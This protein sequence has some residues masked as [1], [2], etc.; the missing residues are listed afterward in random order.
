[1]LYSL[2]TRVSHRASSRQVSV[3]TPKRSCQNA[4]K[5]RSLKR[6]FLIQHRST[7]HQFP[8]I[9]LLPNPHHTTTKSHT[10]TLLQHPSHHHSHSFLRVDGFTALML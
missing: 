2:F 6:A 1:M 9:S 3:F 5:C 7:H 4:R 10:L 8:L